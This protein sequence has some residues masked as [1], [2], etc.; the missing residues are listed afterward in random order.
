MASYRIN[1]DGTITCLLC[2]L[3]SHHP[4]DAEHRYCGNCHLFHELSV[5]EMV[6]P[7]REEEA[8]SEWKKFRK[9]AVQEMRPYVPGE[10]LSG[11]SVNKEDTPEEGGM[12][13]RNSD[14]HEDQWYVAKGFFEANYEEAEGASE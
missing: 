2:G 4:K 1:T 9:T 10:D 14:N 12:I 13:A 6:K 3:T 8:M 7:P 5:E 11:I